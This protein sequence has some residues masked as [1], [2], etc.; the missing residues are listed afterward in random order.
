[1]F[2]ARRLTMAP[3]QVERFDAVAP[4][5]EAVAGGRRPD[6][7][8][9][10]FECVKGTSKTSDVALMLIWLAVFSPRA[11]RIQVGAGSFDQAGEV[12]KAIV[13]WTRALPQIESAVTVH[14][15][16]AYNPTTGTEIEICPADED[17]KHGGRPDVLVLDELTHVSNWPFVETMADN[18]SKNPNC[19]TIIATNAGW[20]DTPAYF[21]RELARTSPRWRFLQVTEPAPWVD[22]AEME[23][24]RRRSSKGR[25]LRLWKGVW[26][27]GGDGDAISED[28]LQA[29][30]VQSGPHPCRLDSFTFY[31]GGLDVGVT[32]DGTGFSVVAV[33]HHF[34][35]LSL[36][37]ANRWLPR[38]FSQGRVQF[39]TVE[40]DI[41]RAHDRFRLDALIYDIAH[42][43]QLAEN[44][45]R[46]GIRC[47][48]WPPS[49][50]NRERM[51]MSLLQ[52]FRERQIAIYPDQ[53]ILD[54]LRGLSVIEK[55]TGYALNAKRRAGIGHADLGIA[56]CNSL[57]IALQ[58]IEEQRMA[59][60]FDTSFEEQIIV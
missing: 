48:S 16:R 25:Y 46:A 51:A 40:A 11:L 32:R 24:A 1:M 44:M 43:L 27:T 10:W 45:A 29:A 9:F 20:V 41:R 19:L 14:N 2:K 57:P 34:K 52:V 33:N 47:I 5:L 58:A 23:E 7:Q 28:D 55:P 21:W 50:A 59:D 13:E 37:Y 22:P 4:A 42:A 49:T 35:R 54:D 53:R 38:E 15:W 36:A 39:D 56:F 6:P 30:I 17:T 31:F 60:Q 3:F 18:A 8:K 12:K 26:N